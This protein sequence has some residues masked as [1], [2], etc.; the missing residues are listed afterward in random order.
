MSSSK[1]FPELARADP[2]ISSALDSGTLAEVFDLSVYTRHVDVVFDRLHAL[3][4]REEPV[5]A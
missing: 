1:D 2:E 5:H 3:T 4:R